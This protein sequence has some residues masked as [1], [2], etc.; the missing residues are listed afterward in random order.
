VKT[1]EKVVVLNGARG[2]SKKIKIIGGLRLTKTAREMIDK[3]NLT[4]QK[5]FEGTAYDVD[6]V[7]T[8]S[9][10][11]FSKILF[12]LVYIGLVFCGTV[13]LATLAIIISLK[14]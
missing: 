9:S 6:I 8:R 7:W 13:G 2:T 14:V 3:R 12:V 10:R 11:A 5:Y 1:Y 4:V